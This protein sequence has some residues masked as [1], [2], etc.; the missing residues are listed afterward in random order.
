[1]EKPTYEQLEK[2]AQS[3]YQQNQQLYQKLQEA[4]KVINNFNA[5]GL[6]LSIIKESEYFDEDFISRCSKKIQTVVTE[7]LDNVEKASTSDWLVCYG[8]HHQYDT[9]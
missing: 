4:E 7:M 8:E 6:L 2:A 5:A 3:M 9:D 1:M